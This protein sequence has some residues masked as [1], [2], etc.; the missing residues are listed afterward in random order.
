MNTWSGPKWNPNST[1]LQ[2][3]VS[4]QGLILGVEHPYYLEPGHGRWEG[5]VKNEGE[6]PAHVK[7]HEDGIR[8][9]TL[10]F[11]LLEAVKG[12]GPPHLKPFRK[13]IDA[14]FYHHR[15]AI[16]AVTRDWTSSVGFAHGSE[17]KQTVADL[18]SLLIE[19]KPPQYSND[20]S[21]NGASACA[22]G[23]ADSK[24]G[25]ERGSSTLI[26]EKRREMEEAATKR[27][28]V[29]AGRLQSEVQHL[30][31]GGFEAKIAKKRAEMEAAAKKVDYITAGE[32]QKE[33]QYLEEQK[34]FLQD[35]E[36]R[37]FDAA[38]KL[39]S[40]RAGRFQEQYRILLNLDDKDHTTAAP[41]ISGTVP[42]SMLATKVSPPLFSVTGAQVPSGF[43]FPDIHDGGVF[44]D[45]Y[46]YGDY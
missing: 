3:L 4:I 14:H 16:I 8:V 2:V 26:S 44:D 43:S 1:V 12:A 7:R 19:L 40:V 23:D 30:E 28:Y 9:G 11:A 31:T 33:V 25:G 27:D 5:Q 24:I 42:A 18:Q 39:D 17:V 45:G 38:A 32:L 37:M 6:H 10:K 35:L 20:G 36:R 13:L 34:H 29:T 46:K 15:D 41:S 22:N 21:T